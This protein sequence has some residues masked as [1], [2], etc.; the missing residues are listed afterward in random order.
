MHFSSVASEKQSFIQS[1]LKDTPI[2]SVVEMKFSVH[3]GISYI[4]WLLLVGKLLSGL[5]QKLYCL[6]KCA[7]NGSLNE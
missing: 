6:G 1:F 4:R 2:M 7:D 3:K 5:K